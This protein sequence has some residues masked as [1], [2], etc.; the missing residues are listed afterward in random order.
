MNYTEKEILEKAIKIL[1]DLNPQVF[2]VENLKGVSFSKE[3]NVARPRGKVMDTWVA[4]I[5]EPIFDTSIFLTISDE[6][7]EPLYIQNK[8]GIREIEKDNDGN[9]RTIK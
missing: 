7:G 8:H 1:N 9:Y 2:K 5:E 4:V 3:D 6:T